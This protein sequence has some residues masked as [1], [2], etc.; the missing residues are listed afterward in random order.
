MN[1]VFNTKESRR[2]VKEY[3]GNIRFSDLIEV[4]QPL[5]DKASRAL[6]DL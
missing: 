3:C 2:H 5:D 1:L 6:D 4:F